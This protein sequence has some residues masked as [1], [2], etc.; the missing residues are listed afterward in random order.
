MK[1][2]VRNNLRNPA[3]KLLWFLAS[4]G[5]GFPPTASAAASYLT[6][7][8]VERG[9]IGAVATA[10]NALSYLCSNNGHDPRAYESART[11]APLEA[12]R[13]LHAAQVKKAAGI[14][15]PQ[16]NTALHKYAGPRGDRSRDGRKRFGQWE[17]AIGA[18]ICL[19]YKLLLRYG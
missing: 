12:M 9:C 10:K 5:H 19:G 2:Q 7:V 4:R 6:S 18:A 8:A 14:T 15:P 3:L 17:L 11:I 16:V 1:Q 13:R